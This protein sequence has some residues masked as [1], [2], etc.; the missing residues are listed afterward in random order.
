MKILVAYS[1]KTGN[2]RKL[3]EAI[4]LVLP[5]ADLCPMA[6]APNP[7]QYDLIFMGCWI[8]K[9]TADLEAQAFMAKIHDKPVALFFS[10]G[11]YPDSA[12]A[13]ECQE[14]V[15]GLLASCSVVDRFMCQGAIDPELIEWMKALPKDHGYGP[16]DSR[17]KL[18]KDAETHPDKDDLKAVSNWATGVLAAV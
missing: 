15:S 9:G 3:A 4:H 6:S 5:D 7:A 16:T 18:W 13:A 1:S 10:L 11:A 17:K 14:T 8:D 2:T 12:H